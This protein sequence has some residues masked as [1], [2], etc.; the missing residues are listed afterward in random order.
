[1]FRGIRPEDLPLELQPLQSV[2]C[3]GSGFQDRITAE[4]NR[5]FGRQNRSS[6]LVRK[7]LELLREGQ[8]ALDAGDYEKAAGCFRQAAA[9]DTEEYR[10]HWG[11]VCAL[12]KGLTV[13][14]LSGEVDQ[15]YRQAVQSADK[16]SAEKYT[17]SMKALMNQG[18]LA[19]A[20]APYTGCFRTMKQKEG[21][22]CRRQRSG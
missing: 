8:A 18:G 1:M 17:E 9:A 3:E 12:T 4:I 21:R 13:P 6:D 7:N 10:A 22:T 11:L 14:V 19:G 16:A 20:S 5:M 15:S 2:A